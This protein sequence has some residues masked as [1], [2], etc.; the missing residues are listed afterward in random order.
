MFFETNVYRYLQSWLFCSSYLVTTLNTF[1]VSLPYASK[2]QTNPHATQDVDNTVTPIFILM[3]HMPRIYEFYRRWE[4]KKARICHL[5][6]YHSYSNYVFNNGAKNCAKGLSNVT[7]RDFFMGQLFVCVCVCV[8]ISSGWG[9][10]FRRLLLL[11]LSCYYNIH[12]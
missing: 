10:H 9:V 8:W 2:N 3:L 5:P 12:L 1:F 7:E 4:R 11:L 6:L